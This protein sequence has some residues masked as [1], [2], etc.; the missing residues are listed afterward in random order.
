MRRVRFAPVLG[1]TLTAVLS[2]AL[3]LSA[4]QS[5]HLPIGGKVSAAQAAAQK[6]AVQ[7]TGTWAASPQRPHGTGFGDVTLRLIIHTTI[8][9]SATRIRLSNAFGTRPVQIGSASVGIEADGAAV[10]PGTL[11]PLT[12]GNGQDG[13]TMQPGGQL[14]SD[15]V[16]EDVPADANLAVSLYLPVYT[17][18]ATEHADNSSHQVS[19]ISAP[20]DHTGDP[21][22][23]WFP[24]RMQTWYFLSGVDVDN[25]GTSA[26]VTLGDS[27]T[28]GTHS[29]T[30]TNHRYPNWL[31]DRLEAAG[32]PYSRLAV[33]NAGIG[34][35]EL[36]RTS[37]CCHAS[38]SALDRFNTDVLDQP[39]VKDIVVMLGTNDI[40]GAHQAT[41]PEVIAGLKELI[42]RAHARGVRIFGATIIPS[43]H[44]TLAGNET[45]LAVNRWITTSGA[46]DGVFDFAAA[47]AD[48]ADPAEMRPS[49]SSRDHLHPDDTGYHAIADAVNLA[50][51]LGQA[52]STEVADAASDSS[53]RSCLVQAS[54]R[55]VTPESGI[56]ATCQAT[57]AA[58]PAAA[59]TTG[60]GG[61][62]V[63]AR[64]KPAVG[65][66]KPVAAI[67]GKAAQPIGG[68]AAVSVPAQ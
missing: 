44:Y 61:K 66:D 60:I 48:P 32:G 56:D 21:T 1:I 51:L 58:R 47:V 68:K 46:F 65:Q 41:A 5:G 11:R 4:A 25:P 31:A 42:T 49:Y 15:G 43:A 10:E 26:V 37:A 27:I 57:P 23:A 40:L 62:A 12:F 30:D 50:D 6:D 14:T 55:V 9:G 24:S 33:L 3:V 39:G 20:G 29:T 36:L 28:D 16:P 18:P 64:R 38:P 35:N 13:A 22:S 52:G 67:G 8:G 7:W 19:Y 45:R 17:G 63:P 53:A 54:L 2:F 34:G 59:G